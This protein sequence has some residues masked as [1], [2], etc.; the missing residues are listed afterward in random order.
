MEAAKAQEIAKAVSGVS[1][2]AGHLAGVGGETTSG[3]TAT[4]TATAPTKTLNGV[5]GE[6]LYDEGTKRLLHQH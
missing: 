3:T 1:D 4:P 5:T 2:A 6:T